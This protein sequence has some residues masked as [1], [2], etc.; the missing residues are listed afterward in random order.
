MSATTTATITTSTSS[1]P[2]GEEVSDTE[3]F[4]T[5]VLGCMCYSGVSVYSSLFVG[6]SL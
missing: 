6:I 1:L 5:L 3:E 2:P 4:E